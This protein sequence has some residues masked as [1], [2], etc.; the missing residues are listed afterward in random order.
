M[1]V[2]NIKHRLIGAAAALCLGSIGNAWAAGNPALAA[3]AASKAPLTRPAYEAAKK[4]IDRQYDA[5]KKACDRTRG[6]AKDVCRAQAKGRLEAERAKLEARYKP[7]PDAIEEAKEATAEANYKVAREKCSSLKGDAED[8]C[9]DAAKA[10][11]EAAIRQARV[12]KVDSTGGV[13][14]RNA[15]SK[16]AP[17]PQPRS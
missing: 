11:R 5:D 7:S 14:G 15:P 9:I 16:S 2:R 10:A 3:P 8:K 1:E 17:G 6:D 4:A 13:F 12:E